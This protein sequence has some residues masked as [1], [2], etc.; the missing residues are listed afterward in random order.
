MIVFLVEREKKAK[1]PANRVG[2]KFDHTAKT[3]NDWLPSFGRVW[4]KG[5]RL[6]SK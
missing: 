6:Q 4:S 1:L 5:R 3:S 2:A